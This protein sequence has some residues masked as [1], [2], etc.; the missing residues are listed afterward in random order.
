MARP[1]SRSPWPGRGHSENLGGGRA[2]V[3]GPVC[4]GGAPAGTS[5]PWQACLPA[6]EPSEHR[7]SRGRQPL[8]LGRDLVSVRAQIPWAW[9]GLLC[10]QH[11][12]SSKARQ[13][14][15]LRSSKVPQ[16]VSSHWLNCALNPSSSRVSLWIRTKRSGPWILPLKA[17]LG[18][19]AA[20]T[21]PPRQGHCRSSP[22]P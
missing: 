10:P 6:W 8:R 1:S 21:G 17:F 4:R 7:P 5:T 9:V 3:H 19:P 14:W 16:P 18:P 22:A 12:Q 13:G 11:V 15:P 2:G 20:Q